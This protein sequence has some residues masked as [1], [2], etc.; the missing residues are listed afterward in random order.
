MK[1]V[2]VMTDSGQTQ[3]DEVEL[4][5]I[6]LIGIEVLPVRSD[7]HQHYD[8][9]IFTSQNAVELFSQLYDITADHIAAIG[10][11][12]QA[13]LEERG[14]TV[15][16]I[17]SEYNQE[18]FI[19]E[20]GRRFDNKR[21]CLP[22]STQARPALSQFLGTRGQVDRIDLYRPAPSRSAAEQIHAMIEA[23]K[24]DVLTFMSPSA[25]DAYYS[26]Y[27]PVEITV[28]AIGPVTR[29][30]LSD[31]GQECVMPEEATK[32]QMI[33]KILEMREQNEF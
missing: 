4:V 23:Q 17:P 7:Y 11:K 5:H 13:A 21:I 1:P 25:V 14:Y 28:V 33:I 29:N 24:V 8:W 15:D 26:L 30:R 31:Y 19:A 16:Y 32:E 20:A 3:T 12:T 2:V 6:P 10:V 22:A 27:A 9:L 18:S